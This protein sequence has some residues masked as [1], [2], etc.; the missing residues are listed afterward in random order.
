MQ[1]R[2]LE[3]FATLT[4]VYGKPEQ[5]WMSQAAL[6]ARNRVAGVLTCVPSCVPSCVYYCVCWA[7]ALHSCSR[8]TKTRHDAG[9]RLA[10]PAAARL[11]PSALGKRRIQLL[12]VRSMAGDGPGWAAGRV[13]CSFLLSAPLEGARAVFRREC[14]QL[15]SVCVQADGKMRC[16]PDAP[17]PSSRSPPSPVPASQPAALATAQQAQSAGGGPAPASAVTHQH[18][19]HAMA[20]KLELDP[21]VELSPGNA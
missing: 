6:A 1:S 4:V 9:A 21:S 7:V 18:A 19:H 5:R 8:R 14:Q 17:P 11:P 3:S 2:I 10:D 15:V 20:S 16:H 12:G 13:G